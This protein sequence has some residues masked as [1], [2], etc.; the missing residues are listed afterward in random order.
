MWNPKADVDV[1]LT[2]FYD[3]AFGPAAVPMRRYYERFD[4]GNKPLLSSHLLATGFLDLQ[5]AGQLA[6]G[7]ADVQARLDHLKQYLR[8][9]HL[10]WLVDR[11]PDKATKKE[12]TLAALTHGYRTRYSYMNHWVGMRDG[13]ANEAAKEFNE[14]SW[15]PGDPTPKKPWAV[16]KPYTHEET[17]A[18]F[19]EG[20]A[21]FRPDPVEEKQ[22]SRNLVPVN[23]VTNGEKAAPVESSQSYQ[24]TLP[25]ALYSVAGE[26]L[27]LSIVTG[28]IAH[29]RDLAPAQWT[30]TDASG[31]RLG[32]GRLPLDG[33]AHSIKVKVP[34]RGLYLL[35]FDDSSAGWQIKVAPGRHATVMLERAHRVE[36]AG[37]MQ[38]M[39][40]YVPRG[41]RELHY[42]WHG[43]PHRVHGPDGALLNE[44]N[45]KS[46]FVK[47]PVPQGADGKTWHFSQMM[48]GY[49]WFFNAPNNLAASPSALLVPKEL[50]EKDGLPQVNHPE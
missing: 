2:D 15:A 12:R 19:R 27:Q 44:V 41:T 8:S 1:L 45:T 9:V 40:F 7:R 37:W 50:A 18:E 36:H 24:W 28:T 13:W 4:K 43:Q 17:E 10:R 5:E 26:P 31:K 20:L 25:Y 42:Y 30:I 48:L 11:A 14:P 22:F 34:R 35:Q 21:F 29:Y 49:L 38:P 33:K 3:K 23:F 16:D 32:S 39:H 46:E 47:I 6:A